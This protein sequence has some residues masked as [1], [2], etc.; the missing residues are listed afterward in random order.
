MAT[1][2][3]HLFTYFIC[4]CTRRISSSALCSKGESKSI[5]LRDQT[6]LK[7]QYKR[8]SQLTKRNVFCAA[9]KLKYMPQELVI[10]M[11]ATNALRA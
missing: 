1:L 7:S 3:P 8:C 2:H 6:L 11:F 4:Q 9:E 5:H 10:I